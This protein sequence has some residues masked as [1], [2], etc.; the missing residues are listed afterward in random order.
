[1]IN[2]IRKQIAWWHFKRLTRLLNVRRNENVVA[3]FERDWT[4]T[5]QRSG[6]EKEQKQFV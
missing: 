5:V 1:M 4:V 6:M 2:K 3:V